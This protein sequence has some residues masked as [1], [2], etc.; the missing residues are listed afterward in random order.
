[1]MDQTIALAS[2]PGGFTLDPIRNE[3]LC[4]PEALR[5]FPAVVPVV[6]GLSLEEITKA[7]SAK[8]VLQAKGGL[9]H[10]FKQV[11]VPK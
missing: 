10:K 5:P 7:G 2:P 9:D 6:L 8:R 3:K 11:S 4:A 1:M